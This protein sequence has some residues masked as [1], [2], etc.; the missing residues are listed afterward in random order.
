MGEVYALKKGYTHHHSL[1]AASPP[2][3]GKQAGVFV[4]GAN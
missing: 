2:S 1:F 4:S 3:A